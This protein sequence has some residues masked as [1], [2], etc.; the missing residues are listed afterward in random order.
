MS[1]TKKQLTAI[2]LV[3]IL[4]LVPI[5][6]A[7]LTSLQSDTFT[8]AN[9][10][11]LGPNWTQISGV[12]GFGCQILSNQAKP[13]VAGGFG[14][15]ISNALDWPNDQGV[16]CTTATIASLGTDIAGCM[17]RGA[18]WSNAVNGY[19]AGSFNT[20]DSHVHL[21]RIVTGTFT[22]I[23][24][25]ADNIAAGDTIQIQVS[26]CNP[27][28]ITVLHNGSAEAGMNPFVDSN[29]AALCAGSPG[30]GLQSANVAN[31]GVTNWT[32]Y[33]LTTPPTINNSSPFPVIG[34]GN[35]TNLG[36]LTGASQ[37]LQFTL[38]SPTASRIQLIVQSGSGTAAIPIWVLE[39]SQDSGTS[40]FQVYGL[41][42]PTAAPQLGD[43]FPLY[44]PYYDVYGL[45]G[46]SC[47]FGLGATSGTVTGTL[48]VFVTIG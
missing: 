34:R 9:S 29:A 3:F 45:G 37:A 40:W 42:L 19:F 4:S 39:C 21:V 20:A 33:A 17:V 11:S 36:N 10:S 8:R 2:L 22:N 23:A 7:T 25:S 43:I 13:G 31:A 1:Q 14:E 38:P 26:G 41:T 15:C 48:P 27:V 16:L 18:V 44:A 12:G 32:G 46:A 35:F 24:T 30:I 6:A 47:R 28:S 5:H